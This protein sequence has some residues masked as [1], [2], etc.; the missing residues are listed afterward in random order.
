[1]DALCASVSAN[2]AAA[3]STVVTNAAGVANGTAPQTT[4]CSV[5]PSARSGLTT[6]EPSTR[7]SSD[8]PLGHAS[9]AT[10]I[11]SEAVALVASPPPETAGALVTDAAALLATLTVILIGG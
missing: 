11:A 3:A 2:V 10:G 4:A 5:P 9:A 8:H 1:M 7:A 6:V